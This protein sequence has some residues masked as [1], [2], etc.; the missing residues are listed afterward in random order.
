MVI[1]SLE[2]GNAL[3]STIRC[4][5]GRNSEKKSSIQLRDTQTGN[6]LFMQNG[7]TRFTT[8]SR[9]YSFCLLKSYEEH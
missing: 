8:N 7:T 3:L 6:R 5:R 4:F 9:C 1:F 2:T